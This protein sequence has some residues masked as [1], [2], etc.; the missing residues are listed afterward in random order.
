MAAASS[1][2][3]PAF[4]DPTS[5]AKAPRLI[6]ALQTYPRSVH[7]APNTYELDALYDRLVGDAGW[8]FVNNLDLD[9]GWRAAVEALA[10]RSG[11][12][13]T[14][15]GTATKMVTLLPF[16]SSVW[17]T[18]GPRGVLNL[19]IEKAVPKGEDCVSHKLR[20]GFLVLTHY[21]AP[22][23][24]AEVVSTTGAGDTLTG[25]L[26][27]C[28]VSGDSVAKAFEGVKRSLASERAVGR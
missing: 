14:A 28:L 12:W 26:V 3:I 4:A 17:V 25:G 6:P 13:I 19:R 22:A 20:D 16:A 9:A 5:F 10:R 2:G 15:E 21:P 11:G 7:V 8:E 1:R 27:A 24:Q 18:A 23:A